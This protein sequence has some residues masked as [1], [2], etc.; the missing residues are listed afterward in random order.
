MTFSFTSSVES[1]SRDC[2]S[3]STEPCTSAL[4]MSRSSLTSPV[5]ICF[6]SPSSVM[7]VDALPAPFARSAR[8]VA[9]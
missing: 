8:M 2:A 7:R 4:R 1:C 5:W 9:I 3:A 6:C